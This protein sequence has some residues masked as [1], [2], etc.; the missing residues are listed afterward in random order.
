MLDQLL[1]QSS[2]HILINQAIK[3]TTVAFIIMS[4]LHR[5]SADLLVKNGYYKLVKLESAFSVGKKL[6]YGLLRTTGEGISNTVYKF[7]PLHQTRS[8]L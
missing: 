8:T 4:V 7:S 3:E 2:K 6:L 5:T 1:N